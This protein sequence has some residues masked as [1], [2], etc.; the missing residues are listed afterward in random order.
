MQLDQH[1]A[2]SAPA[3]DDVPAPVHLDP[4]PVSLPEPA[5]QP[6]DA[7]ELDQIDQALARFTRPFRIAVVNDGSLEIQN[8]G[9]KLTLNATEATALNEF[10]RHAAPLIGMAV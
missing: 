10:M 6:I 1:Q 3:P 5:A 2:F 8:H 7:A 9:G 4:A